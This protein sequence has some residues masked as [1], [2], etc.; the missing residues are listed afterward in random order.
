[1]GLYSHGFITRV[2][3]AVFGESA[4]QKRQMSPDVLA[5]LFQQRSQIRLIRFDEQTVLGAA[6]NA[7]N[8][9]LWKRFRTV[10]SPKNDQ[11]FLEK[12]KLIARD[13]DDVLHPTVSGVL[14]AMDEPE[15]FISSAYIQAVCYRDVERNAAYQLDA[16]DI[17]GPLDVQI[18]EAYKFV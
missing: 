9:K 5:Y 12:M 13:E 2:R 10:I 17:T 8:P 14:M 16:K 7:M 3:G 11:E 4:A 1:M 6:F 18:Q 15:S